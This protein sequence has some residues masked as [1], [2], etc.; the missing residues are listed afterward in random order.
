MLGYQDQELTNCFDTWEHLLHPDDIERAHTELQYY[1]EGQSQV[2]E[3]EHRLRH[4]DGMYRWILARGIA[5]RGSD[6]KPYRMAGSHTD[7]TERKRAE[8]EIRQSEKRFF[9]AFYGSP[10][11][12]VITALT[13]DRY[14]AVTS[15][16]LHARRSDCKHAN[17]LKHLGRAA[18]TF[19]GSPE[20]AGNWF[21]TQ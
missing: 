17:R 21:N 12:I 18:G 6:G 10:V 9:Q 20:D 19:G 11:P 4:K 15:H 16:R 14:V 7:I 1:L 13:D 2:Y 3:L 8:E 5:L